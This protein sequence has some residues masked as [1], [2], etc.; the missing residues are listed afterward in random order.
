MANQFFKGE[1]VLF[2]IE[3]RD[4]VTNALVD[5]TSVNI[6]IS[7]PPMKTT[8]TTIIK[9]DVPMTKV[10]AGKYS[11]SWLTDDVGNY[12]VIYK[13]NNNSNITISKDNFTVIK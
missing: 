8:D 1:S 2:S 6:T 3:I 10:S 9:V 11:Y 5:P 12:E 4:T 13:A 7:K